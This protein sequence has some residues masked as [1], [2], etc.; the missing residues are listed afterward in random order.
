LVTVLQIFRLALA[1]LGQ[2]QETYFLMFR[3]NKSG[4]DTRLPK[5][6]RQLS[7]VCKAMTQAYCH[8]PMAQDLPYN[9]SAN[10]SPEGKE[11]NERH[12]AA[13]QAVER[14]KAVIPDSTKCQT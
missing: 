11:P 13:H 9:C 6:D 10:C 8:C 2:F 14:L 4:I 5:A 3:Q 12:I 7:S 1:L